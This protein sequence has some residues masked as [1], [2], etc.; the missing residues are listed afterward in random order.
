[1]LTVR[2]Y[3]FPTVGVGIEDYPSAKHNLSHTLKKASPR[4][5]S[6]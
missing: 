5:A 1:M 3:L 4:G 6:L 2:R